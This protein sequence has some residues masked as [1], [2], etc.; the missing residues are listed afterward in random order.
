MAVSRRVTAPPVI[1]SRARAAAVYARISEDRDGAGLGGDRQREDCTGLAERKGWHVVN[2]YVDNDISAFSGKPRPAYRRLLADI[3]TGV[4]DAVVVWHLDRLHRRPVELEDF[5]GLCERHSVELASVTGDVDL[6]TSAGRLH[7]RIMGAVARH[8]SE[9]KGERIRRKMDELAVNGK[10][11][12]GG[13]R[14]YGY[15]HDRVTVVKL[16]AK[17]IREAAK[18][19]LAG[20]TLRSVCADLQERDEPTVTGTAWTTSVIRK[21]LMSPRIAGQRE[22]RGAIAG[23]ASWPAIIKPE[24]AAR[25][26]AILGDP[27]RRA[28]RP[29][30]RYL[31]TGM[32]RCGL[33]GAALIARPRVNDQ[34][35]YVCAKGPNHRGCG[36][37][38]VLADPLEEFVVEAVLHRLESP[39]LALS[40]GGENDDAAAA[41]EQI[42]SDQALLEDVARAFADRKVTMA[43]WLAART[44]IEKRIEVSTR[45][46]AQQRGRTAIADFVGEAGKLRKQWAGLSIDRRRAIVAALVE[47]IDVHPARRGYNRFDPGRFTPVWRA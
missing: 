43:E 4:V 22:H 29:P 28:Q 30:R 31:L 35:A 23:D 34:R 19:I 21:L 14:P 24:Q 3:E 11:H 2:T 46:L 5:I 37:I 9:H 15:A 1:L 47:H 20:D 25:L 26:R 33:C 12:G 27:R 40:I 17:V 16:E 6:A 10:I 42:A 18:R 39:E 32:L 44:P 36:G 7:A 38:G 8:E 13:S 41:V 45:R